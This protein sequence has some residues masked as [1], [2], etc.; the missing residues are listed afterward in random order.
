[1]AKIKMDAGKILSIC[2]IALGVASTVLS[3]VKDKNDQKAL[4]AEITKEVLKDLS[5]NQ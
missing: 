4:K 1:M 2:T 5:S 3:G